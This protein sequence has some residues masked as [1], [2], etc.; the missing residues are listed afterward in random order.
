MSTCSCHSWRRRSWA[1][2]VADD[3]RQ[4]RELADRDTQNARACAE[5]RCDLAAA[6]V[7]DACLRRAAEAGDLGVEVGDQIGDPGAGLQYGLRCVQAGGEAHQSE[8]SQ[9]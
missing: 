2:P 3:V 8:L 5:G 6:V 9:L 7:A 1:A 4:R